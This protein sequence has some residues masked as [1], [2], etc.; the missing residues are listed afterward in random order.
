[1]SSDGDGSGHIV[2]GH[3]ERAQHQSA[4]GQMGRQ[5]SGM[6]AMPAEDPHKQDKCGYVASGNPQVND[7]QHNQYTGPCQNREDRG[8]ADGARGAP[9]HH[10]QHIYRFSRF[11]GRQGRGPGIGIVLKGCHGCGK[12]DQQEASGCQGRIHE[13][14]PKAAEKHLHHKDGKH[15]AQRRHPKGDGH[16]QIQGQQQSC[17]NRRHVCNCLFL[18]VKSEEIFRQKRT[19]NGHCVDCQRPGAEVVDSKACR[20]HQGYDHC[21]HQSVGGHSGT[22]MGIR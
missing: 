18:F 22:N 7:S 5:V 16:R 12:R 17:H 8:L 14:L 15:A 19:G 3:K 1:M 9:D 4:P 2:G 21:R 10:V 20:R 11:Q 6:E 13:I